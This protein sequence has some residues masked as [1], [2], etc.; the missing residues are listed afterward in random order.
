MNEPN[1]FEPVEPL[2]LAEGT[3]IHTSTQTT[4]STNMNPDPTK[5]HVVAVG[6]AKLDISVGNDGH[7]RVRYSM[8]RIARMPPLGPSRR[9]LN[10]RRL[11]ATR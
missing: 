2:F 5:P 10:L 8:H 4:V 9:M 6:S 3:V 11:G 7:L 1:S